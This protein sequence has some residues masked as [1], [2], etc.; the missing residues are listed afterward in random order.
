MPRNNEIGQDDEAISD[1]SVSAPTE[2]SR[3]CHVRSDCQIDAAEWR[4]VR[5]EAI[6]GYDGYG[7][8]ECG[9]CGELKERLRAHNLLN[10]WDLRAGNSCYSRARLGA[11]YIQIQ[12]TIM[13]RHHRS[14][15]HMIIQHVS[16]LFT[17]DRIQ[18]VST[19]MKNIVQFPGGILPSMAH[20]T[21]KLCISSEVK[22]FLFLPVHWVPFHLM[23]RFAFFKI[24]VD[25]AVKSMYSFW[26]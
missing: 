24:K 9:E 17:S 26:M 13:P 18:K 6:D 12:Y 11:V 3:I 15:R 7:F 4:S 10:I 19:G 8:A 20:P 1:M 16:L 22:R 25:S 5:L 14:S 23:T 21:G 2:P